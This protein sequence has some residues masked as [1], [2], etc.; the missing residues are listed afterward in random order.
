MKL[1]RSKSQ[2][3]ELSREAEFSAHFFS[4]H[5]GGN[6]TF[7][8]EIESLRSPNVKYARFFSSSCH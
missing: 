3:I 7:Q 1:R 2:T 8:L 6:C 4:T 5:Y